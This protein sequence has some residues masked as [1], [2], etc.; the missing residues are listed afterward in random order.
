MTQAIAAMEQ[1]GERLGRRGLAGGGASLLDGGGQEVR[2]HGHDTLQDAVSQGGVPQSHQVLL[3]LEG[4]KSLACGTFGPR[5]CPAGR[6]MEGA[7]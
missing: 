3:V 1:R 7:E 5:M 6:P 2:I 4:P